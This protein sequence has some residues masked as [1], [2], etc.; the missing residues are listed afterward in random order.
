MNKKGPSL[1]LIIRS[2]CSWGDYTTEKKRMSTAFMCIIWRNI[3][4]F[5]NY[6]D[7]TC[8]EAACDSYLW[9]SLTRLLNPEDGGNMTLRS[10][11]N[12]FKS[13]NN[14]TVSTKKQYGRDDLK[15]GNSKVTGLGRTGRRASEVEKSPR[16]TLQ[17]QVKFHLPFAIIIRISPYSPR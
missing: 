13:H 5:I 7:I 2:L 1:S 11:C 10:F 3:C 16:L 8:Q 9:Y 4:G 17:R 14:R 6:C 15:S 12:C